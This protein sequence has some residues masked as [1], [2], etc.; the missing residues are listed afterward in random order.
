MNS[1]KEHS[2]RTISFYCPSV[3]RWDDHETGETVTQY[4]CRPDLTRREK[5]IE[6]AVPKV[7]KSI[8]CCIL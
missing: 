7:D 6:E 2:Y 4:P 1:E 3:I 8:C 5:I